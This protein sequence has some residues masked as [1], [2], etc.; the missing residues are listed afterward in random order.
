MT[1][2]KVAAFELKRSI[3]EVYNLNNGQVMWSRIGNEEV[4]GMTEVSVVGK[5]WPGHFLHVS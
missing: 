2:G 4:I 5:Q 1:D 3:L